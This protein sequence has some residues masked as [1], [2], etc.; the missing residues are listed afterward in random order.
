[1]TSTT[2]LIIFLIMKTPGS[3]GQRYKAGEGDR[4]TFREDQHQGNPTISMPE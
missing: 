1:M 3:T 4:H 2:I